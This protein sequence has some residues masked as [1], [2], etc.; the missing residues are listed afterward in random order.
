MS[1][2]II[3]KTAKQFKENEN[4]K[5]WKNVYCLPQEVNLTFV[6]NGIN[7]LRFVLSG[8]IIDSYDKGLIGKKT[9]IGIDTYRHWAKEKDFSFENNRVIKI[10]DI[11]AVIIDGCDAT[12]A[13]LIKLY[14]YIDTLKKETGSFKFSFDVDISENVRTTEQ[15]RTVNFS[16]NLIYKIE[17]NIPNMKIND[18]ID[19]QINLLYFLKNF[20]HDFIS[21]C[22][23]ENKTVSNHFISKLHLYEGNA[24]KLFFELSRDNQEKLIKYVDENYT[25][26]KEMKGDFE[27]RNVTEIKNPIN[28]QI[29]LLYFLTNFPHD[30]IKECWA[31]SQKIQSDHFQTKLNESKGNVFNLFFELSK[32]NQEKL[33]KYVDKKYCA[34][35]DFKEIKNIEASMPRTKNRIKH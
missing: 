25:R 1:N 14:N 21:K 24:F 33:L 5:I 17:N 26:F 18:P 27:N 7:N 11:T 9:D 28:G 4:T 19:G 29:N 34:F 3:L 22:W 32:N 6:G 8:V 16:K 31:D 12:G 23:N 15:V 13:N 10:G 35:P 30:F 20:P 2:S